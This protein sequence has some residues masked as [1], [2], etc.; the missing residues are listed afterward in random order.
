MQGLKAVAA[1]IRAEQKES[2][3]PKPTLDLSK[4]GVGASRAVVQLAGN[5]IGM[6]AADLSQLHVNLHALLPAPAQVVAAAAG[7]VLSSLHFRSESFLI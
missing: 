6:S 1:R 3:A 7:T 2:G 4:A 5:L